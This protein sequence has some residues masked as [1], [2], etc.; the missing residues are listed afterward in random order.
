MNPEYLGDGVYAEYDGYHIILD[1]TQQG[2]C[3]I[4]LE[5]EVMKKLIA[6]FSK[7]NQER[8]K[9]DTQPE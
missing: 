6:Y 2:N 7:I 8:Q 5:P 4:A 1:L 9:N 3:R